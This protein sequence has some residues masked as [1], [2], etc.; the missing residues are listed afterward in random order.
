MD[1]LRYVS[2]CS[3]V[4]WDVSAIQHL[5]QSQT[6]FTQTKTRLKLNFPKSVGRPSFMISHV[7][8]SIRHSADRQ[9]RVNGCLT[10]QQYQGKNLQVLRMRPRFH[11]K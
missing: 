2:G 4:R 7:V 6:F 10:I 1:C 11:R 5:L 3:A 9:N 8:S